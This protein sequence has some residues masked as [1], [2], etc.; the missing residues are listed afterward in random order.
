MAR[1]WNTKSRSFSGH[2]TRFKVDDDYASNF[3]RH[4]VGGREHEELRVPAEELDEFYR[5][6]LGVI[7]VIAAYFGPRFRGFVPERGH[8]EG[9]DAAGQLVLLVCVL[10]VEGV[11]P[12][13]IVEANHVAILLHYPFWK[14]RDF[15]GEIADEERERILE[16]IRNAWS[17]VFLKIPLTMS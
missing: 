17:S 11:D 8:L 5:H 12:G 7:T 13:Q 16:D 15:S 2:V 6:I 4:L 1:D 3:E 9:L 10:R 14:R